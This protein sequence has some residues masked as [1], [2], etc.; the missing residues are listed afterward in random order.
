MTEKTKVKQDECDK[1]GDVDTLYKELFV[2]DGV[3]AR[4]SVIYC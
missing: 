1:F 2:R 3:C 4:R